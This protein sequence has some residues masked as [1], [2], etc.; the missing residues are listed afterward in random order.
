M[1]AANLVYVETEVRRHRPKL[2]LIGENN[3]ISR[4]VESET[5]GVKFQV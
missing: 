4:T 5:A 2:V 3:R 1:S